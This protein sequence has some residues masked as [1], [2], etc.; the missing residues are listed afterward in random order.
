MQTL[1]MNLPPRVLKC[2]SIKEPILAYPA[3]VGVGMLSFSLFPVSLLWTIGL[4]LAIHYMWR[5]R[6]LQRKAAIRHV[7]FRTKAYAALLICILN[8]ST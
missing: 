4:K 5:S 6:A 3:V 2:F 7:N 8:V 1:F